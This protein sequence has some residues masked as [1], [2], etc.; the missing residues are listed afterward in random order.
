VHSILQGFIK[1]TLTLALST[2]AAVL[3]KGLLQVGRWSAEVSARANRGAGYGRDGVDAGARF[4]A[5]TRR[6][7]PIVILY[8]PQPD[9]TAEAIRRGTR[10]TVKLSMMLNWDGTIT[11]IKPVEALPDG[12]TE[13]ALEAAR[14]IE[15]R[16]AIVSGKFASTEQLVDFNF[17]A[18]NVGFRPMVTYERGPRG[19]H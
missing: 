2:G 7:A 17:D 19:R 6:D 12:L 10:G 9:R 18:D 14:A 4:S 16:P 11:D 3:L 13:R 5:S 8:K 1:L 15:F